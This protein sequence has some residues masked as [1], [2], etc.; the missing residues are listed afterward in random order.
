MTNYRRMFWKLAAN[1]YFKRYKTE[2]LVTNLKQDKTY[3]TTKWGIG[4]HRNNWR[5]KL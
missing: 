1:D 4:Y 3:P 2:Y 5:N